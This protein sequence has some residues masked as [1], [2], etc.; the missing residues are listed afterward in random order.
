MGCE[1]KCDRCNR[2]CT[3]ASGLC[4]VC[5][6]YQ[7]KNCGQSKIRVNTRILNGAGDYC[8]DCYRASDMAKLAKND[9]RSQVKYVG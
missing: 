2:K 6:T 3:H 9:G 5:R 1:L 7:C 4:K 8:N